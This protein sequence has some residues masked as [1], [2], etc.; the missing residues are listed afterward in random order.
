[1]TVE[2]FSISNFSCH[3]QHWLLYYGASNHMCL[4]RNWFFSY[5]FIDDIIVYMGNEISCKI[6]GIGRIQIKMHDG[7]VNTLINVRHVPELRKNLIC[8][9]V[10]DSEGYKCI[11]QGGVMK[12]YKD[13]L[14][15][16]KG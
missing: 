3:D 6:V 14:L 7:Y 10:L 13:I 2:V 8:L 4:H 12:A 15:V 11:V 1:M 9:G 5:Q 16:M